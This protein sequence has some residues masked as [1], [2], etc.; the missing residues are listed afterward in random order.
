[1]I[2]NEKNAESNVGQDN[3][4]WESVRQ[5]AASLRFGAVQIVVHESRVVQLGR[6]ENVRI[7][8]AHKISGDAP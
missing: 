7:A 6:T 2:E 5:Q 3:A 4:W 8:P 1:M